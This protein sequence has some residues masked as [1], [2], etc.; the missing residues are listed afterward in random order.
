[1][2]RGYLFKDYE[3][4]DEVGRG[5]LGTIYKAK[6]PVLE[7]EVALK[8]LHPGLDTHPV[9]RFWCGVK[10]LASLKHPNIVNVYEAGTH[11]HI[12]FLS[13]EYI[14]GGSIL[15][16]LFMK[17]GLEL[18]TIIPVF[19]K[20]LKAIDYMHQQG[21]LHRDLKITNVIVDKEN[22]PHLIDFDI[23][24]PI[25]LEVPPEERQFVIGTYY[26]MAPER[27]RMEGNSEQDPRVDVYSVGAMLYEILTGSPPYEENTKALVPTPDRKIK[28][29]HEFNY[30]IPG[31]L[32]EICLKALAFKPDNR[33]QTAGEFS[34]ALAEFLK[35]QQP[36]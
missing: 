17:T 10:A 4:I 8:V 33:F 11:E 32:D 5:G 20:I 31:E 34:S 15:D 9:E 27:I 36:L 14:Q 2:F 21:V 12:H 23:A 28:R 19:N 26:Y 7:R 3:I 29:P 6:Q 1:M 13:M 25:D 35:K 16:L 24:K 30:N 22:N 18:P